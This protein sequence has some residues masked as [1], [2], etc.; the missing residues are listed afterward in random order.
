MSHWKKIEQKIWL[1]DSA[2][3]KIE[4]VKNQGKT[5]VFTNGC[6]D[7]IHLGHIQYLIKAADFG[8][9]LIVGINSASSVRA[10]KGPSRPINDEQTRIHV[11][12]SFEFVDAVVVFEELTPENLIH[13][14]RP[15]VLIK[16]GDYEEKNII[17][18]D[19]VKSYGGKVATIPFVD[20][21][22]STAIEKKIKN[23]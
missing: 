23:G 17:G 19:F 12:A 21:Y 5:V 4:G 16:G 18:S 22:S 7:L 9:Y 8:D 3:M 20:G 13:S 2:E 1:K 14:I 10:L 15:D 6:F 11:I